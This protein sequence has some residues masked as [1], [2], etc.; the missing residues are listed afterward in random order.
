MML[1]AM[2]EVQARLDALIGALDGHDAG[3]IIAATEALATAV[4]L[5]RGTPIP[6]GSEHRARTLIGQTL[7]QLEAAATRVNILKDWTRQRI[8][9]SHEIRGTRPG[10]LALSY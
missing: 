3:A 5:F 6:P 4:I 2:D 9:R 1:A 10:G 8:D 7:G